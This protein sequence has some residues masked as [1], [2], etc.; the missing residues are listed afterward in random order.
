MIVAYQGIPGAYSEEVCALLY[1]GEDLAAHQGFADVVAAVESGKA[2]QGVLPIEN[3]LAGSVLENYDLLLASDLHIV[4][5]AT[6]PISHCLLARPGQDPAQITR[7]LSHPQA[8]A[9][10]AAWLTE[11]GIEPQAAINTAVAARDVARS[12]DPTLCAIASRRAASLYGLDVLADR[13]QLR[14]DNATRFFALSRQKADEGKWDKAT[15]VFTA[16]NRPGSLATCLAAFSGLGLNLTRLESRPTL[17][18][19]WEYHFYADFQRED[20]H[21]L[22]EITLEALGQDLYD[23]TSMQRILGAYQQR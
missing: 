8:L 17:D 2:D 1:P 12:S 22:D 4:S 9:Q 16:E 6:L 23:V 7:C 19:R 18:M 5:E 15:I 11:Q 13:I 21:K 20:G 3:S 14:S 10:C